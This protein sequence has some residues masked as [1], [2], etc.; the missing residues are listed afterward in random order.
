MTVNATKIP[1]IIHAAPQLA[2]LAQAGFDS[3]MDWGKED[4]SDGPRSAGLLDS[5]A[6]CFLYRQKP[7]LRMSWGENCPRSKWYDRYEGDKAKPDT[8]A[9]RMRM[10]QGYVFERLFLETVGGYLEKDGGP[11]K[12]DR[13]MAQHTLTVEIEG[14]K[15]TGHPDAALFYDGQPYAIADCKQTSASGLKYWAE[16]RMPGEE[17]GYRHQAGN[18]LRAAEKNLG[19]RFPY[20][21]WFLSLRDRTGKHESVAVGWA[22]R[23]E[24]DG[25]ADR[26]EVHWTRIIRNPGKP[27]ERVNAGCKGVPCSTPTGIEC[28]YLAHCQGDKR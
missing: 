17:W 26:C 20:F 1:H 23:D 21:V 28:R 16:G 11:W 5:A 4:G 22:S 19:L 25:Y 6:D 2:A 9:D 13:K 14:E 24:V 27:P 12:L 8:G 10:A 3:G 18:Y 7:R 15:I